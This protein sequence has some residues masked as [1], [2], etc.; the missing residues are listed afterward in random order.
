MDNEEDK[1]L[2]MLQRQPKREGK[3]VGVDKKYSQLQK[4]ASENEKKLEIKRK[5][6]MSD[7]ENTVELADSGSSSITSAEN[8]SQDEDEE[9]KLILANHQHLE[10]LQQEKKS[11]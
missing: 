10:S 9:Y 2:L 11:N 3:M 5:R 4:A 8:S 7:F 1:K 6:Q